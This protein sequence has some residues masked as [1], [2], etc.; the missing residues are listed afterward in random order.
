MSSMLEDIWS[1][2]S[3]ILA[4]LCV[5]LAVVT[6]WIIQLFVGKP[7]EHQRFSSI[8]GLRGYLAFFVFL[9]HSSIWYYYLRIGKWETPPSNLFTNFGQSSVALFFMITSFLFVTKLIDART[10]GLSWQQLYISR[11]LRL[12]PLYSIAMIALFLIVGILSNW[13]LNEAVSVVAQEAY[14]WIDSRF[15]AALISMVS[16]TPSP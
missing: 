10:K 11:F 8:D 13:Q 4:I 9:H 5:L 3:P 1:P 15:R 14:S 7:E 6:A 12:T 2:T 16:K